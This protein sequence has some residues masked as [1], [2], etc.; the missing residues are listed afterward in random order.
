MPWTNRTKVE[1]DARLVAVASGE[2]DARR[3]GPLAQDRPGGAVD[4]GVEQDDVL[5]VLD[6]DRTT[7]AP[8]ST[9]PVASTTASM[10][11][12]SVTAA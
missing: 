6:G 4:L 1:L 11:S 3:L 10:P 2:D 8:Y 5:A 9:A 12:A 7:W